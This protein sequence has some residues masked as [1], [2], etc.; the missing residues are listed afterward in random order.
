MLAAHRR[1]LLETLYMPKLPWKQGERE[2][3]KTTHPSINRVTTPIFIVPPAGDFDHEVGHIPSPAEHILLFGPRLFESRQQRPVFVDAAYLDDERHSTG[4][5]AHPLYALLERARLAKAQ[6]WPLT[7]LGR[8]D[9]YQEAT[10]K[11]HLLHSVPVAMEINLADLGSPNLARNLASLSS[12]V[13][14]DPSD[15]ALVINGGPLQIPAS[16]E[17]MFAELLIQQLNELP[18]LRQWSQITFVATSL[19]DPLKISANQQKTIRRAEWHIRQ[20]LLQRKSELLRM[21]VF[22]DYGVEF[23][24]DLTPRRARPT[25]KI[26]YTRD[27]DHFY[28]KGENVKQSGYDA[29]YPVSDVVATCEGFKGRTFSSGD[30]RILDWHERKISTGNAPTW[31][32]AAADHHFATVVPAIATQERIQLETAATA[33]IVEQQDLFPLIPAK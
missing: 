11:F 7:G 19:S 22:G 27:G 9:A 17:A 20:L 23:T 33:P 14:C 15:A 13:S 30:A 4:L 10:A 29:I 5:G 25:A 24:K 18:N 6:A 28:A 12:Q 31:R 21:P 2:A 3:F 16:D 26:S 32:W 1:W 8:S